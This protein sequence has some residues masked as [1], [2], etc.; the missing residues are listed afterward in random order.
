M[1]KLIV[2][3]AA[4]ASLLAYSIPPQTLATEAYRGRFEFGS[5]GKFC[6]NYRAGNFDVY[7][8]VESAVEQKRLDSKEVNQRYINALSISVREL[9]NR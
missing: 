7:D 4:T 2:L 6:Y 8:L 3:L 1:K 9:C 5:Y